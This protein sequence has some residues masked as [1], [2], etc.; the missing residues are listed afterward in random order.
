MNVLPRCRVL[1]LATLF[2]PLLAW[3]Q[4]EKPYDRTDDIKYGEAK[5]Q[6]LTLDVFAPSGKAR[7]EYLKP[8]DKGK[9]IGLIDVVSG[10]WS[11]SRSRQMDH[12]RAAVFDIFT[13][14]GYTVFAVRPGSLPDFTALEMVEN[15]K[16]G[17]RW[18]KAHAAEYGIDPDRIGLFG[19]SAGGHLSLL[20]M[21]SPEPAEP[22]AADP[23][24]HYDTSVQA[25]VAFFP[26]TDFVDFGGAPADPNREPYLIFS[27]GVEGKTP[28]QIETMMKRISPL[29][30]LKGKTPPLL[31]VHGDAD[32]IVPLQ[33]SESMEKAMKA[34]GDD[35]ELYVKKGGGHFW[36]TIPQ[37]I[38]MSAEWFDK[39]LAASGK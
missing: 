14:H 18:V 12:E 36:L 4:A 15:V 20:T 23:L 21:E 30:Q 32:P 10:G 17:I 3:G 27:D 5:G 25:V 22:D 7:H 11:S 35:V 8:S 34:A 39:H 29:Y 13:A 26:P 28:E 1:L 33:Q 2:L 9:G 6:V 37:E 16:Q 38:I 24:L 19:A 31:L